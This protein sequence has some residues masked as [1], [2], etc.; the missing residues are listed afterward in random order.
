MKLYKMFI[1]LSLLGLLIY[2]CTSQQ[3]EGGDASTSD[4]KNEQIQQYNIGIDKEQ[5]KNRF[6]CDTISLKEYVLSNYDANSICAT[7]KRAKIQ[8]KK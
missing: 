2:S 5:T 6:P 7:T 4:T 8:R 3:E 1:V